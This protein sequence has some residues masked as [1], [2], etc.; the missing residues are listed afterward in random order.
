M[1]REVKL[2][3]TRMRGLHFDICATRFPKTSEC[4]YRSLVRA[5]FVCVF[6]PGQKSQQQFQHLLCYEKNYFNPRHCTISD[7]VHGSKPKQKICSQ[8]RRITGRLYASRWQHGQNGYRR[9]RNHS[10]LLKQF[11]HKFGQPQHNRIGLLRSRPH[12]S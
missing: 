7:D 9:A 12:W 6:Y 1:A 5:F 8:N 11:D 4:R 3:L 10:I 2:M